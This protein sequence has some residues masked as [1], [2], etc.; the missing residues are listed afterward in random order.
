MRQINEEIHYLAPTQFHV[1]PRQSQGKFAT[2]ATTPSVKN[3]RL[4]ICSGAVVTITNFLNGNANDDIILLG[5]GT[6]TIANNATIKTNTGANILLAASKIYR[7]TLI[8]NV[9]YMDA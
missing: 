9:W 8:N 6:T 3:S 4:W 7:F 2:T 5:D 1:R